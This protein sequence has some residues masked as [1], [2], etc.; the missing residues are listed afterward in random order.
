LLSHLVLFGFIYPSEYDRV[1]DWVMYELMRRL[2]R[3]LSSPAPEDR[4]CRGTLLSREQYLVDVQHLGCRDARAL[5]TNPMSEV[6]I[7]T[8]TA[9]IRDD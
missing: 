3:S 7:A 4:V 1:P 2:E 6:D 8:W 5:A 9:A